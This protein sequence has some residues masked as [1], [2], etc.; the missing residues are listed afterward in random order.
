[1]IVIA[2][3]S[4]LC[5]LVLIEQI[6]LLPEL[7]SQILIPEGVYTEL[8]AEGAPIPLR[9]WAAVPPEWLQIHAVQDQPDPDLESLHE[10][11][12][13]AIQLALQL[14]AD[15]IILDERRARQIATDKGLFIT[16]LLGIL[17]VAA[18]RRMIDLPEAVRRLRQTTFRVSPS[19]LERLLDKHSGS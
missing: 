9:E 4:P 7:F 15:L 14:G 13:Q 2:D 12:R 18:S 11:E 5:Y 8:M 1:M 16:G 6:R 3:T 19:L 10:G 17:D